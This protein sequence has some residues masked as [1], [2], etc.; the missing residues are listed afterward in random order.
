M[1]KYGILAAILLL[2]TASVQANE[3]SEIGQQNTRPV[4][5]MK[6]LIQPTSARRGGGQPFISA[7]G[8][9]N[10]GEACF[11]G[12]G[13]CYE[14]KWRDCEHEVFTHHGGGEN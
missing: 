2:S 11:Q 12:A 9:L 13:F 5:G 4:L 10:Y 7:S 1:M 3:S 14:N 8:S 6:D